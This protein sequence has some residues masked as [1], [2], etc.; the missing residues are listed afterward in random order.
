MQLSRDSPGF[1]VTLGTW[2]LYR[3]TTVP[4]FH[5]GSGDLYSCPHVYMVS[6]KPTKPSPQHNIF[7]LTKAILN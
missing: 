3:H 7:L 6:T 2:A 1:A 5:M 4:G